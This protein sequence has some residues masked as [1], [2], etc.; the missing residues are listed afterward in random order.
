MGF[1]F[2]KSPALRTRRDA[3]FS[4]AERREGRKTSPGGER[5]E[6][7]GDTLNQGTK[8]PAWQGWFLC[9]QWKDR[10]V[11]SDFE[12]RHLEP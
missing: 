7:A 10:V 12:P 5:D 8:K 6:L 1:N 4:R 11:T 3:R 9:W 2:V